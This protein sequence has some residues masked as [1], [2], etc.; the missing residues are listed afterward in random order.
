MITIEC[1]RYTEHRT[2]CT[3]NKLDSV[4]SSEDLLVISASG[5]PLA[6]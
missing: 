6:S 3:Q 2:K 5:T 4:R 1:V